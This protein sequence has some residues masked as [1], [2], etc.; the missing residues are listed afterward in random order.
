MGVRPSP[1]KKHFE[2]IA[3]IRYFMDNSTQEG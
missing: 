3:E 1:S 2:Q